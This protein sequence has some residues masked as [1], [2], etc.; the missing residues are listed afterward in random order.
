MTKIADKYVTAAEMAEMLGIPERTLHY[1]M[2]KGNK[3][4]GVKKYEKLH[5]YRSSPYM[6][7]PD[8]KYFE[9]S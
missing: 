5:Q 3:I 1:H 9:K 6:I 4:E 7:T 8:K 2:K